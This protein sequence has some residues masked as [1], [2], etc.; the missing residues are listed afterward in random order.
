MIDR[1][2]IKNFDYPILLATIILIAIGILIIFSATG[3]GS[4]P[5]E[6][7]IK[8]IY[9]FLFSIIFFSIILGI[10]YENFDRWAYIFYLFCI[11]LLMLVFLFPKF[12]GARRWI[13]MGPLRLQPSEI[14]KI[15]VIFALAK[16]LKNKEGKIRTFRDMLMPFTIIGIPVILILEQPDMGS[17]LT[18]FPIL[19]SMLYVIGTPSLYIFL[20]ISPILS[21]ILYNWTYLWIFYL[22]IVGLLL[23]WRCSNRFDSI[24]AFLVNLVTGILCSKLWEYLKDYQKKRILAFLD[25]ELDPLGSGYHLIQSKIAIGSGG[26]WGKGFMLGTQTR[27]DF[28]PAQHTDFIFSVIGEELGFWGSVVILSLFSFIVLRG[29]DIAA[30]AKN[31]YGTLISIG[32][33]SVFSFHILINIGMTIG[34]MPITGIPL[35]LI[36]YGGSSLMGFMIMI[37]IL[38]NVGMRRFI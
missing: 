17:A 26:F 8:Q 5:Q 3:I 19:L 25:P 20:I 34:I 23:W 1:R 7:Y 22:S 24:L 18:Y 36:S 27:L 14:S 33:V 4:T 12:S 9:W 16:Y 10:N 31:I 30:K 28:L 38:I 29:I 6:Y 21:A 37:A 13:I 11:L 2:L 35:P 15:G 32:I